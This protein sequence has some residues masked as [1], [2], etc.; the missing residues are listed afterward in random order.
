MSVDINYMVKKKLLARLKK[1][2]IKKPK[3]LSKIK[4]IN[5]KLPELT[6]LDK[7]KKTII[8]DVDGTLADTFDLVMNIAKNEIVKTKYKNISKKEMIDTVKN[9]DVHEIIKKYNLGPIQIWNL[10]RKGRKSLKKDAEKIKIFKGVR[11]EL[12]KLKEEFN[13]GILTS[14]SKY[15]T[16]KLLISND[17]DFFDFKYYGSSLFGKSK[18]LNKII[19][20]KKISKKDVIYI[21]DETRDIESCKKIGIK[22]ISVSWGYNAKSNLENYKPDMIVDDVKELYN[23]IKLISKK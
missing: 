7:T 10:V 12:L 23:K 18:K 2:K 21:G 3:I 13:I 15:S 17:I 16:N 20:R 9:K 22:V 5:F 14:N 8:F 11:E 1:I 6:R 19:S 4:Q